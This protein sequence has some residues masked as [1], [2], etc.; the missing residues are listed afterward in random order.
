MH[1]CDR[2]WAEIVRDLAKCICELCGKP[3]ADAHHM[4][5][6]AKNRFLRH[7]INNGCYLC[8]GC[9]MGFHNKESQTLWKWFEENRPDDYAFLQEYKHVSRKDPYPEVLERLKSLRDTVDGEIAEAA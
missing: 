7:S 9:H 6:R 3:G 1:E 2:L 5:S 4:V 8:K